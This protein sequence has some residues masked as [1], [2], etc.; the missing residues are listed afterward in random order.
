MPSDHVHHITNGVIDFVAGSAGGCANVLV[1]QPLDTV[2]VKM[3]T[4]PQLYG[5]AFNCFRQTLTKD[6][7]RRGLYAGT[8]PA[9][10]ANVAENSVLFCGYGVCQTLVSK[11]TQNPN[12]TPLENAFAGFLAAFF[13]SF[14]L[15]P[16]ELVKCKL[17]ALRETGK[18]DVKIGAIK[19]TGDILRS[20]GVPGLFRG[21][22]STMAREM[23]GYFF[24]FGSYE[25]T[26]NWLTGGHP[27]KIGLWQTIVAGGVGGIALWSSIFPF[28]VVKSRIQVESSKD[29]MTKVLMAILRKEGVRGLYKGLG[30]TLLRTFP[31]TGA[32]FVA[33]EYS[34]AYMGMGATHMG[35]LNP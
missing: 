28:D 17:Q 6:G 10:V 35:L 5:N 1:G 18:G 16:T 31:S 30:P 19:L 21:L 4:F 22:T 12:P 20:E 11:M 33:Y 23:P 32:L 7:I 27:E 15:C 3:Q 24:F 26:K 25:F 14:T 2:K 34:K 8:T 29:P 9:L 13:S